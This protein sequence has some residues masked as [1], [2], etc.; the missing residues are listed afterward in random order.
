VTFE[1]G[2]NS[3]NIVFPDADLEV[4]V[5]RSAYGIFSAA[6][7]SCMAASRTLV[8]ASVHYEFVERLAAKADS[9][10]IGDP[11]EDDTQTGAQ[12]ARR[13][14]EKIMSY[15]DIATGEG[16]RVVAGGRAPDDGPGYFFTPTIFDGVR[17][18]MRVAREEIFGPVTGVIAFEDEADAVGKANDTPYGLAGAVWTRDIKRAHRGC[19]SAPRRHRLDQQ[20][21]RVELA[22]AIRRLQGV[23]LRPRERHSCHRALHADQ[24]G[25]GRPAGGRAG[26]GSETE[27]A[28]RAL[29]DAARTPGGT[30]AQG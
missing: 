10:R 29:R 3:P 19:P 9:I 13:Q 15:I 16:A 26:L 8:H 30:T 6:G 12:T 5:Q 17:N 14:L 25:L 23:R 4:A 22:D 21:P 28:A 1:L 27:P 24:V 2:G 20:L 18:D 11:L 7:Q